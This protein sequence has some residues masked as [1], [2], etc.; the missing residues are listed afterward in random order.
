METQ[1]ATLYKNNNKAKVTQWSVWVE[2]SKEAPDTY[3]VV[4][5]YGEMQGKKVQHKKWVPAG[6]AKRTV[7]EQAYLEARSKWNEKH[8][9][10]GYRPELT[11]DDDRPVVTS[12][13]MRPMLANTYEPA[14]EA[15]ADSRAY[16]MP[17]PCYLQR[18][19]DGIRCIARLDGDGEEQAVNLE[20]RQGTQFMY[21]DHIRDAVRNLLDQTPEFPKDAHIDGEL[22]TDNLPF[23]VISGAVRL[24]KENK[25]TA[26][27][28]RANMLQI[29]YY[30]YDVYVPSQPALTFQQ[31][32]RLLETLRVHAR[33]PLHIVDTEQAHSREE[34]K[35]KHDQYVS[36]GFEGIMLRDPIGIYECNKRSKYLQKYKEFMEEEFRIV[37]FHEGVGIDKGLV[38]WDCALPNWDESHTFAVKPRGSHEA[39]RRAFD[40]AKD[41]IGKLLTVIFQEYSADGVPRFPVGKAIRVD[42]SR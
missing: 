41:Q 40:T 38:I 10:E 4:C 7:L 1:F 42:M 27:Q 8:D 31:R 34:V 18:K 14:K 25:K 9:R 30:V 2:P 11:S 21:F 12:A 6:K 26:D 33:E 28:D 17:F 23:E 22:Y 35:T 36:E 13:P 32:L 20:S 3:W 19:L 5:E 29:H 39:R 15:A 24:K 16:K 37:G